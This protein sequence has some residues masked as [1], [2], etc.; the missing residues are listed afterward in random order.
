M[1]FFQ[2]KELI[3]CSFSGDFCNWDIIDEDQVSL[4]VGKTDEITAINKPKGKYLFT[5]LKNN[6][7]RD[8]ESTHLESRLVAPNPNAPYYMCFSFW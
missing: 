1:F 6:L 5:Y 3:D 8:I 7:T 2:A 4:K